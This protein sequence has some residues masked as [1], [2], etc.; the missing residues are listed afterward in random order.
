M[1]GEQ[2]G[3]LHCMRSHVVTS[4]KEDMGYFTPYLWTWEEYISGVCDI[5]AVVYSTS[6]WVISSGA[7]C[8]PSC[9]TRWA[10]CVSTIDSW[11]HETATISR[12]ACY[13]SIFI[14]P[15]SKSQFTDT[16]PSSRC[17]Q[18]PDLHTT[19]AKVLQVSTAT[20]T[21]ALEQFAMSATRGR[22][23]GGF[24]GGGHGW[25]DTGGRPRCSHCGQLG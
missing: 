17:W 20:S 5:W 10:W 25:G 23:R 21:T 22:G 11:H 7:L 13:C 16:G 24:R 14:Q 18:V 2:Y 12:G 9:T 1:V 8:W 3:A 19:F 15:K 4:S 6:G